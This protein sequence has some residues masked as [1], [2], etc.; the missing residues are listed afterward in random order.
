[1]DNDEIEQLT[2]RELLEKIARDMEVARTVA[3]QL[4]EQFNGIA[5]N[6][7]FSM[8]AKMLGIGQ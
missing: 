1:M 6:P 8:F 3:E 4:M 7:K 2:D 5:A